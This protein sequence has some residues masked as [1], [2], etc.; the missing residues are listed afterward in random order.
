[1]AKLKLGEINDDKPVKLAI[2]LPANAHRDVVAYAEAYARET[3]RPIIDP[4]K[5]FAP[6]HMRFMATDLAFWKARRV[7]QVTGRG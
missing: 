4:S 5:L 6:M 1:M 7:N 3:G 2:E